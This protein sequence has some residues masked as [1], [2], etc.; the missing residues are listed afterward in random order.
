M[1]ASPE[2]TGRQLPVGVPMGRTVRLHD[3]SFQP[4]LYDPEPETGHYHIEEMYRIE[5]CYDTGEVKRW[6]FNELRSWL[7][8][9]GHKDSVYKSVLNLA[10][11]LDKKLFGSVG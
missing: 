2:T 10:I 11:A 6:T 1:S 8:D 9:H 5:V 4:V 3:R 7:R